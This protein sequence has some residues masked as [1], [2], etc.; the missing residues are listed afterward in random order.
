MKNMK[1]TTTLIL[2]SGLLLISGFP[3]T[4]QQTVSLSLK[5]AREIA[6]ERAFTVRQSMADV[7]TARQQVKELTATGLPQVNAS[8][9]YND[10]IGLPVQLVPG[11]FFGQPG[12]DIEVQFGTKYSGN[13]GLSV[14]QLIFSGS[15]LVGLQAARTFLAKSEE[16]RKK[17][18]VDIK[19][20]V[21][22][23]YFLVL[24]TQ[25]GIRIVDST[26]A[27][28]EKL[29]GET[30]VIYE[31]GLTEETEYDQLQLM[32]SELQVNKANALNQLSVARSFLKYHL[33]LPGSTELILTQTMG[34]LI[35]EMAPAAL[36]DR[37][38]DPG[39]NIDFRILK[40]QQDLAYLDLRRQKSLYL[41]SVSAFLN[42]QTQAQRAEWDFFDPLGKWYS[43]SVWGINMNIPI[44]SSGERMA[45]VKQAR[46]QV[47]KTQIAEEQVGSS[48]KIQHENAASE[49]RNALLTY[50]TTDQNR[51]LSG[52]I[53]LR[54][55]IKFQEGLAGSLDLMNAHNQ[56]L[57]SQSQYINASLNV[58]NRSVA[59]ESLLENPE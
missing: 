56:Y 48:L 6:A 31:N 41:P 18:V 45:K 36:L 28:T 20:T 5:Q 37:S 26:L 25:E 10:N 46:V 43:S 49:L 4:A 33:G 16:E 50:G 13:A 19:K 54:T 51:E 9:G 15:Y 44:F 1:I 42:Y 24:A 3:A 39:G 55:S 22:E 57:N 7:E 30:R 58:L 35:D 8:V 12:Q 52:K 40:K 34:E 29:A 17:S 47:E 11:D 38:F 32:V 53:Y 59:M 14:N 2:L 27:I 23:A 21:S